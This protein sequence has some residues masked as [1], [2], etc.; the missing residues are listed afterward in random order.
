MTLAVRRGTRCARTQAGSARCGDYPAAPRVAPRP[1]QPYIRKT[2]NMWIFLTRRLRRWVLLAI[3]LPAARLLVHR[4]ALAAEHRDQSTRTARTLH[5]VDSAVTAVSR[6]SR[7]KVTRLHANTR[8]SR[9]MSMRKPVCPNMALGL[10]GPRQRRS[11]TPGCSNR[12]RS[13]PPPASVFP[14]SC[15]GAAR[16]VSARCGELTFRTPTRHRARGNLEGS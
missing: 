11:S 16:K 2:A 15:E 6:R 7:R 10:P 14:M 3:A 5:Q 13:H 9:R 12:T 1:E 8:V 4:L